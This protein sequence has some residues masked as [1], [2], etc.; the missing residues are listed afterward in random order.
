M[1]VATQAEVDTIARHLAQLEGECAAAAARLQA[2]EARA[3]LA[4]SPLPLIVLYNSEKSWCGAGA[5]SDEAG[6]ST[7]R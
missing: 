6:G 2:A 7:V 3:S 4:L 1:Q 5:E